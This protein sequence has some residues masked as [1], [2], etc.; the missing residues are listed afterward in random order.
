MKDAKVDR[1][2]RNA[3]AGRL[4]DVEYDDMIQEERT[5]ISRALNHVQSNSMRICVCVRKRPLFG[6]E[7]ENGEIDSVSCCNPKILVHEPK[8]KVDGITKFL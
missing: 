3:E 4:V 1:Q 6:K 7:V 8:I 5:K 2:A